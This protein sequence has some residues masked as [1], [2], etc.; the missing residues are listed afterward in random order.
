MVKNFLFA[1]LIII[2]LV[3][4]DEVEKTAVDTAKTAV[5]LPDKAEIISDLASLR[6]TVNSF[7]ISNGRFPSSLSDLDLKTNRS[8]DEF[9]Y[10]SIEGTVKH[11]TYNQL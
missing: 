2:S 4:C 3:S 7:Y 6:S 5:E 8:I 11:K 9:S 1:S 10:D